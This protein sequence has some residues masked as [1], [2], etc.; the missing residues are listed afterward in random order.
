MKKPQSWGSRGCTK[1]ESY[2]IGYAD[3]GLLK[4]GWYGVYGDLY[5][6]RRETSEAA[7]VTPGDCGVCAKQ[8]GLKPRRASRVN[9]H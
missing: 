8:P 1:R 3:F 9:R 7:S 2:S 6:G 5:S 4:R